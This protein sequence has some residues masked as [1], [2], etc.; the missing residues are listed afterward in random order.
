MDRAAAHY[1]KALAIRPEFSDAHDKLGN[2]FAK[3]GRYGEAIGAYRQAIDPGHEG[4][5]RCPARTRHRGE[6]R[7]TPRHHLALPG[8]P[9]HCK[10]CVAKR[11]AT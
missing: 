8:F 9:R 3:H 6:S 1:R 4:Q 7:P 2:A 5:E 10:S 11:G